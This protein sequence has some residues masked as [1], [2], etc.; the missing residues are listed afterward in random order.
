MT[1]SRNGP[2]QSVP[3]AI[4]TDTGHRL[5]AFQLLRMTQD[6][7]SALRRQATSRRNRI[8]AGELLRPYFECES[9]GR[10]LYPSYNDAAIHAESRYFKHTQGVG[11][12]C[13]ISSEKL[14][15]LSRR[16]L[17]YDG[18]RESLEHRELK[19]FIYDALLADPDASDVFQ[20]RVIR[21]EVLTH[22]YRRP[23]VQC[24]W[25]DRRIV[26]E[27]QLSHTQNTDVVARDEFYA[28]EGIW[29]IWVF[30]KPDMSR[31]LEVDEFST[32]RHNLF[33]MTSLARAMTGEHRVLTLDCHYDAPS[34]TREG[35]VVLTRL[36]KCVSLADLHYPD[37]FRPHWHDHAATIDSLPPAPPQWRATL[38]S[39][40]LAVGRTP[41]ERPRLNIDKATAGIKDARFKA[42]ARL[43]LKQ[44][45]HLRRVLT[46]AY[47]EMLSTRMANPYSL[48]SSTMTGWDAARKSYGYLMC[49]AWGLFQPG[50]ARPEQHKT[51]VEFLHLARQHALGDK[52]DWASDSAIAILA[53]ALLPELVPAV[54]KLASVASGM[55]ELGWQG[56]RRDDAKV[57]GAIS[58]HEQKHPAVP[59]KTVYN[60]LL[61]AKNDDEGVAVALVRIAIGHGTTPDAIHWFARGIGRV[62]A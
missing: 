49:E 22:E 31:A 17:I 9:C 11:A 24:R 50:S 28:R 59:W 5:A 60:D 35:E 62:G 30:Q 13:Q 37:N 29:I 36:S 52:P 7:Y 42:L 57:I 47:D 32:N 1:T 25:R 21:G 54:A 33:E 23:D 41:G 40:L 53:A 55:E 4:C 43:A 15:A 46:V 16:A 20:E 34:R 38:L 45:D 3:F 44:D 26:F 56:V 58:G 19:Q 51:A 2:K 18:A 27:I 48:L 14:S 61:L 6:D 12:D 8:V 39:E 10:S